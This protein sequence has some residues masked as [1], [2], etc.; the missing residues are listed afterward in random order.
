MS[1]GWFFNVLL[2]FRPQYFKLLEQCVSQ[3]VLHKS[4]I[5]PDFHYTKKF[6]V[7]VDPLIGEYVATAF[8]A[9]ISGNPRLQ[10]FVGKPFFVLRYE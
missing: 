5:D 4:G 1:L 3:I 6:N 10:E 7:D 8:D 2:I 9:L